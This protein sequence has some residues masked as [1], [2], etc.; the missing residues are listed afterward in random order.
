MIFFKICL[1]EINANDFVGVAMNL[2]VFIL[3]LAEVISPKK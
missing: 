2:S 1:G 3:G